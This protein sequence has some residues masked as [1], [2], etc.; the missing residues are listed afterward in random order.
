MKPKFIPVFSGGTGRSGTTLIG[1]I[2]GK[3]P[4]VH[5][6]RPYEIKFLTGRDGLLDLLGDN[7]N[8]ELSQKGNVKKFSTFLNGSLRPNATLKQLTA[9]HAKITQDWWQRQGKHGGTAGLVKG[10]DFENL[11]RKLATLEAEYFTHPVCSTRKFF[12]DFIASNKFIARAEFVVDTTPANIERSGQISQ[13]LTNAKFIHMQRDGRDTISSVLQ[14][15]WGPSDPMKAI[16]WWKSKVL[17]AKTATSSLPSY[18]ILDISL[19]DLLGEKKEVTYLALLK[20]LELEDAHEM[21]NYL[22]NEVNFEN[23]HM[24][25][26]KEDPLLDHHFQKKFQESCNELE[27]LGIVLSRSSD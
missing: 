20:F 14:E 4:R 11:E 9:F 12:Y 27:D 3:H 16:L 8:S 18:S 10:F 26:W 25:R 5:A 1:K 2:L 6:G 23:A 24:N 13:F 7:L 19:E 22:E 17:K 21:R 15:P